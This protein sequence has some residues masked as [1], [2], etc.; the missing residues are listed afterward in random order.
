MFHMVHG[1][2][3]LDASGSSGAN[4]NDYIEQETPLHHDPIACQE[5]RD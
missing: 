2:N 1:G 5:V 4:P 3:E